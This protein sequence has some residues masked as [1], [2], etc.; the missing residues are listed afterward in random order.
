[1]YFA[2]GDVSFWCCPCIE[3]TIMARQWRCAA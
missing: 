3:R 1:M 2:H